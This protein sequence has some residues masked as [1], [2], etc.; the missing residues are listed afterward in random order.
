M[1]GESSKGVNGFKQE[2]AA[3]GY[4]FVFGDIRGRYGSE[5]KFVMN[6]PIVEHKTKNDVDE[7]KASLGV[8]TAQREAAKAQLKAG[9]S[10]SDS[11][12]AALHSTEIQLGYTDIYAPIDGQIGRRAGHRPEL[13]GREMHQQLAGDRPTHREQERRNLVR[14]VKRGGRR[15]VAGAD[16]CA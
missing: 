15:V 10:A 16:R 12:A 11:A 9:E 8:N 4:I 2:L 3:S 1:D 6:R 14:P 7:M 5:G 13:V